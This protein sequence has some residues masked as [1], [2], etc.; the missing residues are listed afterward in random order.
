MRADKSSFCRICSSLCPIVVTVDEGVAI[1]V[2]GDREAPLYEVVIPPICIQGI[3]KTM[4]LIDG[5]IVEIRSQHGRLQSGRRRG[6]CFAPWFCLDD[7]LLW[8]QSG[9]RR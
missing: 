5:D 2:A 4:G 8:R 1:K 9:L 7:S 3:W 6:C